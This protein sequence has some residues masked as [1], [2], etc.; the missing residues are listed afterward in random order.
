MSSS[1][2][3]KL[4]KVVEGDAS[5]SENGGWPGPARVDDLV[6][7]FFGHATGRRS[8]YRPSARKVLADVREELYRNTLYRYELVDESSRRIALQIYCGISDIGG[9]LWEQ[10]KRVLL[11][12]SSLRHPALPTIIDGGYESS[13]ATRRAGFDVGGFA[14][15]VTKG[16][17]HSLATPGLMKEL[18]GH[19]VTAVRQLYL[20]ADGLAQL[21]AVGITHRNLWA[22]TVDVDVG[23]EESG[24]QFR[25]SRFEMSRMVADLLQ[26]LVSDP[27]STEQQTT[28]LLLGQDQ[29]ALAY[30]SPERLRSLLARDEGTPI[31]DL[32]D[33]VFGLGV[34]AWQ[35]F[36]DDLPDDLT[37]LTLADGDQALERITRLHETMRNRLREDRQRPAAL[38][39]LIRDMLSGLPRLRPEAGEVVTRL[40]ERFE[41]L[42]G[43]WAGAAPDKPYLITFMPT[44]SRTTLLNDWHW[45][46]QDPASEDGRR[47][48]AAF[49]E[50]DLRGAVLLH[51][52]HGAEP[53][54]RGGDPKGKRESH[55]LLLGKKAAWFCR[56]FRQRSMFGSNLGP[57]L[58][59]VLLIA[60]AIPLEGL[61]GKNLSRAVRRAA[62]SRA[63]P[64]VEAV[65]FDIDP[66]ELNALREGRPKW[67]PLIE[68]IRPPLAASDDDMLFEQALDWLL[69]FQGVELRAREYPYQIAER[70]GSQFVTLRLD[71]ERDDARRHSNG[72]MRRFY[73]APEL[74]PGF[75]EFFANLTD[76]DG[77]AEI[78]VLGDHR[79]RPAYRQSY[80]KVTV[81]DQLGDDAIVVR[82]STATGAFPASGWIRPAA[83]SGTQVS[84]RRQ[85]DARWELLDNKVLL[86]QLRNPSTIRGLPDRYAD[87]GKGLIGGEVV[88][89]MLVSEPF[90]A[91]QG[92]PGTGK[93][94]TAA[95]ALTAHLDVERGERLLVSAQSNYALDNLA[96]R[97]LQRLGAV[98][99]RF[100]PVRNDRAIALR[101]TTRAGEERVDERIIPF[102]LEALT[103]RRQR[104]LRAHATAKYEREADGTER[105]FLKRWLSVIDSCGP[106]L[107]DRLQ[108]GAS[109]VFATCAASIPEFVSPAEETLF[110]W[111]LVEEAAKAWPTELAIP[112]VR[113]LRW[114]L[115]GDHH[116]L[117]AHRRREVEQFLADTH[118]DDDP[119]VSIH[120]ERATEYREVFNIFGHLFESG[121]A[122]EQPA[123]PDGPLERPVH[124]L[125]YQFRMNEPI[126]EVV[127]RV[128]YPS[129]HT[130]RSRQGAVP[131]EGLLKTGKDHE[132]HG[133]TAPDWV[134]GTSLIWLDTDGL[135]QCADEYAWANPGEVEVASGFISRLR[136]APQP[137]RH[138]LGEEPLAVLTPYRRQ[139]DLLRARGDLAKHVHTVHSFQGREADIV[140]VSLVR[141][142]R[143]GDANHPWRSIG[144]L[145]QPELCNVLLSRARRLLVIVGN[146]PHFEQSGTSFWRDIGTCVREFG[147][148]L[149]ADRAVAP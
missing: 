3:A 17:N 101:V 44:E 43:A 131:P 57:P 73:G 139:A 51:A 61:R 87:A 94:E 20:L 30:Y 119:E 130:V 39:G 112:L 140:V 109:L 47:E 129:P 95:R 117:P 10:E 144:H 118:A 105:G 29:R 81:H 54:I 123:A 134:A 34:L 121:D 106:E 59:D 100:R 62:F 25:L 72:L 145:T 5:M 110:D 133:L 50:E 8:A 40:N 21:H 88:T 99:K 46:T 31:S 28:R 97:I 23:D 71:H 114:T 142:T 65:A 9:H 91:L 58:D 85:Y 19:P 80:G 137:G 48:L 77:Q 22:G 86:R 122:P 111:V 82:R 66:D 11:R 63:I 96:L 38:T 67:K 98:D 41:E 26:T 116:Q 52:P 136:P 128:F 6:D 149:P 7:T 107:A 148:V 49:I 83:D 124:R 18:R 64:Q 79:G 2:S 33:D 35:W 16:A 32:R 102:T 13:E 127:S 15:V 92:P 56:P 42:T 24:P 108:R 103:A 12:A 138:G 120:G 55:D 147:V 89:D 53:Y 60:Y 146:L 104:E 4:T 84:L 90:F 75:G 36:I 126:S 1:S 125:S 14:F 45:L 74:R 78:E 69:T 143:R 141:D 113:G 27:R 115:I 135:P 76:D 37:G 93:T 68:A 70:G 132:P